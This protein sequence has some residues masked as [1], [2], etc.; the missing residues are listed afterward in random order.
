MHKPQEQYSCAEQWVGVVQGLGGWEGWRHL[1]GGCGEDEEEGD[2]VEGDESLM[3]S[4]RWGRE[5]V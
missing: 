3:V 1:G 4:K 5:S 2:E